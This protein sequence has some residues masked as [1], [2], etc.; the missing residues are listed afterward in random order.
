MTENTASPEAPESW[1]LQR[2]NAP[3]VIN[4]AIALIFIVAGAVAIAIFTWWHFAIMLGMAVVLT[5]AKQLINQRRP[6]ATR[7]KD[8][9]NF[10]LHP[11]RWLY[12]WMPTRLIIG[13]A[14]LTLGA[15]LAIWLGY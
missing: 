10:F 8:P 1:L 7:Q 5:A 15:M 3:V 9:Y 13:C 14:I 12:I 6:H 4:Y 11:F 2:V